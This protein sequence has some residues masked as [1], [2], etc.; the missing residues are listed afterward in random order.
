[1][2]YN[3]ILYED[4]WYSVDGDGNKTQI[5]NPSSARSV[6]PQD[7]FLTNY[8]TTQLINLPKKGIIDLQENWIKYIWDQYIFEEKPISELLKSLPDE[9]DILMEKHA[10][11][12]PDLQKVNI[13][14]LRSIGKDFLIRLQQQSGGRKS[15]KKSKRR[16]SRRKSVGKSRGKKRRRKTKTRR[17]KR[18]KRGATKKRKHPEGSQDEPSGSRPRP[19]SQISRRIFGTTEAERRRR[20]ALFLNEFERG[21]PLR[22][23]RNRRNFNNRHRAI[24]GEYMNVIRRRAEGHHLT[25]EDLE[26]LIHDIIKLRNEMQEFIRKYDFDAPLYGDPNFPREMQRD[27]LSFVRDV[28]LEDLNDRILSLER[29]MRRLEDAEED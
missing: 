11:L 5:E 4:Q 1:M 7:E 21:Q 10:P 24:I 2:S 15:K 8:L 16:K 28:L 13:G 12:F 17:R 6:S 26:I 18:K 22:D 25:I 19:R 29:L 14:L 20:G 23:E 9:D 3:K 27:E